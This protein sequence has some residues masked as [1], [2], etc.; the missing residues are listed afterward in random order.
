MVSYCVV[1][2]AY[3]AVEN[4]RCATRGFL[5]LCGMWVGLSAKVSVPAGV[6]TEY[7]NLTT[8]LQVARA[9]TLRQVGEFN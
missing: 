4:L 1:R 9:G 5:R 3:C 8:S 7:L 2:D 6:N